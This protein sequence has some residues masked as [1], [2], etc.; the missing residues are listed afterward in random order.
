M[1]KEFWWGKPSQ[2]QPLGES[3]KQEGN[4]TVGLRKTGSENER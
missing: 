1:H 4:I 2:K 3:R